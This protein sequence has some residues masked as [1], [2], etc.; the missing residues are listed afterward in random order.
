MTAEELTAH[1]EAQRAK[2]MADRSAAM[3]KRLDTDGDG[4]LSQEE[5]QAGRPD[6]AAHADRHDGKPGKAE[7]GDHDGKPG[8]NH[9]KPGKNDRADKGPRKDRGGNLIERADADGDGQV[10]PEEYDAAMEKFMQH[11]P[12]GH[13][14]HRG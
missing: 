9:G 7:R 4:V 13:G 2:R 8:K 3:V 10:T 11:R 12:G 5:L 1:A 6:R 14:Q